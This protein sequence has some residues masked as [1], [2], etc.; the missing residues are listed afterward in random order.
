MAAN[1]YGRMNKEEI[2]WSIKNPHK[3]LEI[4]KIGDK[5]TQESIDI[6]GANPDVQTYGKGAEYRHKRRAQGISKVFGPEVAEHVTT[7]HETGNPHF[8][9]DNPT[10]VAKRRLDMA[11]NRKGI[12]LQKK[13]PNLTDEEIRQ[14]IKEE[15]D[16]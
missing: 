15:L 7:I 11:S 9:P 10:D 2:I 5:A 4:K 3:A 16:K 6:Y 8:D 14:K 12:E 1:Q 13:Y